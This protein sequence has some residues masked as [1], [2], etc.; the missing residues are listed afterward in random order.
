M[1]GVG[2]ADFTSPALSNNH[3]IHVLGFVIAYLLNYSK[4]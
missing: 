4:L 1:Y 3:H 2:Y